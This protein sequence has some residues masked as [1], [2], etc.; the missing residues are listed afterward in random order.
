MFSATTYF[1]ENSQLVPQS[2][3]YKECSWETAADLQDDDKIN[4]YRVRIARM[5]KVH[6]LSQSK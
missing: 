4:E 2:L 6:S 3:P 5:S 1:S